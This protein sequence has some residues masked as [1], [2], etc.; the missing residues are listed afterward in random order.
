MLEEQS[1]PAGWTTN[2]A[3]GE[4]SLVGQAGAVGVKTNH[5][6]STRAQASDHTEPAEQPCEA[7]LM[8][9]HPFDVDE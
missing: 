1:P 2:P 8:G 9:V 7:G 3:S 5:A 6:Y 4:R